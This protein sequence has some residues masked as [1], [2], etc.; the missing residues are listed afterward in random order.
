[1][2]LDFEFTKIG[3]ISSCVNEK[4]FLVESLDF[5]KKMN[6]L[7][8]FCVV[9]VCFYGHFDSLCFGIMKIST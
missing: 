4:I 5:G 6:I 3:S 2:R 1:M 9:V 7:G 8:W